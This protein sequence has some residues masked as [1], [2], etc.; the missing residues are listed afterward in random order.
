MDTITDSNGSTT[1]DD[2]HIYGDIYGR[3]SNG[4]PFPVL[5][6]KRNSDPTDDSGGQGPDASPGNGDT[7]ATADAQQRSE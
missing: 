3:Y 6:S 5:F 2:T 4:N 7:D 1:D